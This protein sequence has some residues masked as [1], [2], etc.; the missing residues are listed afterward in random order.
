MTHAFIDG[1]SRFITGIRVSNNNRAATVF[2]LFQS[3]IQKHGIPQRVRGDH[4]GENIMVARYM[5][6]VRG[7]QRGSYI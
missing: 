2:D 4:G 1:F 5:E 7:S 3:L 6:E